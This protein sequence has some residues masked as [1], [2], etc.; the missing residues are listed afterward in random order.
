MEITQREEEGLPDLKEF[1][2]KLLSQE[3]IFFNNKLQ[4]VQDTINALSEDIESSGQ[5]VSTNT[6][7]N[8]LKQSRDFYEK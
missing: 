3:E 1:S 4:E 8:E 5:D 6:E 7:L 2:N